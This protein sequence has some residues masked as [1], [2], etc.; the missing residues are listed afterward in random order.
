MDTETIIQIRIEPK[1]V[2]THGLHVANSVL[3]RATLSYAT[4]DGNE[5]QR[6][7]AFVHAIC[8]DERVVD[9]WGAIEA[10]GQERAW[11]DLIGHT[12]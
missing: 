12:L 11:L 6:C 10:A 3:T 1:L 5:K 2:D 7:R 9:A 8:S 4:I